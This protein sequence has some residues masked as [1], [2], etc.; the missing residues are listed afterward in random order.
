VRKADLEQF[1]NKTCLGLSISEYELEL[2]VHVILILGGSVELMDY[3]T[4]HR[5]QM[6]TNK[7]NE[8]S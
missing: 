4:D 3:E 5:P 6:A 7:V 8:E 2:L 1:P